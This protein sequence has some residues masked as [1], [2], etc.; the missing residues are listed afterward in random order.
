MKN[1]SF[2]KAMTFVVALFTLITTVS[3][4][5]EEYELSEDRIDLNVTAFQEGIALPLGSTEKFT[6]GQLVEEMEG[7]LAEMLQ[8]YEGAYLFRIYDEQNDVL[9]LQLGFGSFDA[10]AF[11]SS[12]SFPLENI[13]LSG[14]AI[15][16]RLIESD[17]FDLGEVLD[18]F[19]IDKINK[20]L[21]TISS[22]FFLSPFLRAF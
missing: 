14:I 9:D 13:D 2:N 5:N 18:E 22:E 21:P 1:N 15:E 17:S 12:F 16:G 4:I 19:D 7:D 10:L 3:C 8:V 20:D 6:L 11:E